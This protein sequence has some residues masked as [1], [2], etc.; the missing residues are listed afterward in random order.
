MRYL[1]STRLCSSGTREQSRTRRYGHVFERMNAWWIS[2]S[3]PGRVIEFLDVD[4][5]STRLLSVILSSPDFLFL[6]AIVNLP[7]EFTLIVNSSAGAALNTV[8][9]LPLSLLLSMSVAAIN[10]CLSSSWERRRGYRTSSRS[11]HG[12]GRNDRKHMVL[13]SMPER[14][15]PCTTRSGQAT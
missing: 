11:D 10:S 14:A 5:T 9:S 3:L 6:S 4:M 1:T 12:A 2:S 13:V 15:G 8:L 7:D